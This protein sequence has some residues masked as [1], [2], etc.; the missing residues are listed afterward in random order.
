MSSLRNLEKIV[1]ISCEPL[2]QILSRN[3]ET[4]QKLDKKQ[5]FTYP[6]SVIDVPDYL[7]VIQK[8]MDFLT[9]GQ[10]YDFSF[11]FLKKKKFLIHLIF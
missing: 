9:I 2:Y 8:P 1:N 11:F 4:I 6:V 3:L 7:D 5:I 10:K